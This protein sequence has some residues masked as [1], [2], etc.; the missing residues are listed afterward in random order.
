MQMGE[1]LDG[2]GR[3]LTLTDGGSGS[4]GQTLAA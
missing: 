2:E 3:R 1:Q 4:G